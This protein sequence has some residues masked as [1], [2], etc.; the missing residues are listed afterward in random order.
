MQLPHSA[1]KAKVLSYLISIELHGLLGEKITLIDPYT[2]AEYPIDRQTG[3]PVGAGCDGKY[4]TSDDIT[5]GEW[6]G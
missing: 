6:P 5:L 1:W 2:G 4:G 3:L